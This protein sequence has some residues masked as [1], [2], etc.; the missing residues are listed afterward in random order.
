MGV[1]Y[2]IR[3]SVE[4]IPIPQVSAAKQ[5][6]F[7]QLVD[8]ILTAKVADPD[9]DTTEQEREIDRLVYAL[10]GLTEEEITAVENVWIADLAD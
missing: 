3:S 6:P 1:T 7:I 9:A 4:T 2:W 8:R 5:H 10:Y